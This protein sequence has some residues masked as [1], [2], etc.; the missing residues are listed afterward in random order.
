M[1]R[2]ENEA[3]KITNL[4]KGK[5]ISNVWRHRENEIAIQFVDGTRLFVNSL[6]ASIEIS[7]THGI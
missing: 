5:S 7:I 6:D 3:E 2:L 1:E 4:L